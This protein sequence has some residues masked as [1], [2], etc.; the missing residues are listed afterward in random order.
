M[1]NAFSDFFNKSDV[2]ILLKSTG[3]TISSKIYIYTDMSM[4]DK[5][6]AIIILLFKLSFLVFIFIVS[7]K[8]LVFKKARIVA[9]K[10]LFKRHKDGNIN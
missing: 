5:M 1:H 3:V 6:L 4:F 2:G 10:F 7:F 9:C 8:A